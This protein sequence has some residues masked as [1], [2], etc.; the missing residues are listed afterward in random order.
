MDNIKVTV[1]IQGRMC[2]MNVKPKEEWAL[3]EAA[4][5]INDKIAEYR[6][7][8]GKADPIDLLMITAI[9]FTASLIEINNVEP[10]ITRLR[11]MS[12]KLDEVVKE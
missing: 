10:I 1:N 2:S 3:R 12:Q 4:R 5:M 8:F 11:E 7:K 6:Q 9:Q